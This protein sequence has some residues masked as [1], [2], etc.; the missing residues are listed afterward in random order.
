MLGF[1]KYI[2]HIMKM[3]SL[4]AYQVF[5]SYIFGSVWRTPV[6]RGVGVFY[7]LPDRLEGSSS[8]VKLSLKSPPSVNICEGRTQIEWSL[9]C[10]KGPTLALCLLSTLTLT[11]SGLC[12]KIWMFFLILCCGTV[13]FHHTNFFN[14]ERKFGTNYTMSRE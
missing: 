1:V 2:L 4:I 8:T 3:K 12:R 7:I 10:W 6:V 14:I 11:V 5:N 13:Y 9:K